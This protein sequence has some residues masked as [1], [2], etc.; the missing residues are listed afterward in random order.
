[1]LFLSTFKSSLAI[2]KPEKPQPY[3]AEPRIL[4]VVS[5]LYFSILFFLIFKYLSI[6]FN[7]FIFISFE[8]LFVL[9]MEYEFF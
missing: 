5:L 4:F 7:L 6:F 1:M 3:I 2:F 9:A 8:R